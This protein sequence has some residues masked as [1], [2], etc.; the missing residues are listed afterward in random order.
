[1]HRNLVAKWSSHILQYS[2]LSQAVFTTIP[3]HCLHTQYTFFHNTHATSPF[4][5]GQQTFCTEIAHCFHGPSGVLLV[6]PYLVEHSSSSSATAH[7][8][9]SN[10]SSVYSRRHCLC[11][12]HRTCLSHSSLLFVHFE[13]SVYYYTKHASQFWALHTLF[14]HNHMASLFNGCKRRITRR[15]KRLIILTQHMYSWLVRN[16]VPV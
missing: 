15:D 3:H 6:G 9:H 16:N 7:H 10:S 1:M 12:C 2:E 8:W 14:N 4:L 5:W 11:D 13:V